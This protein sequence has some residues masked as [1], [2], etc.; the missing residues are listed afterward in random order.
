M[1]PAVAENVAE[2]AFAGTVTGWLGAGNRLLLLASPTAVPPFEAALLNV[3]THVVVV[4]E[5]RLVGLHASEDSA[6]ETGGATKLST[7]DLETPFCRI[8]EASFE[9]ALS[10]PLLSTAVVT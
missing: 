10:A 1:L 2:V 7:A 3:T 4:P 9:C 5:F 8:A 6:T